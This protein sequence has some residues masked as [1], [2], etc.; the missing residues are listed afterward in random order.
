MPNTTPIVVAAPAQPTVFALPTVP[1]EFGVVLPPSTLRRINFSALDFVTIRRALVE[2][3][4]AYFPDTFND[5]VASNGVIMFSEL[6]AS[7][8]NTLSLREDVLI[9]EAFLPT[10]QTKTAVSEHLALINQAIKR[11]TP[12]T[13]DIEASINI[14]AVTAVNI[15]PGFLFN[16]VGSDGKPLTYEIYRAPGDFTS[17]ISIPPGKAGVVAFGIE[18]KFADTFTVTSAGGPSQ[19]VDILGTDI[20][21]APIIVTVTTGVTV[22]EFTRVADL[23]SFG[24]NDPVYQVRFLDDRARLTFGDD[25][26][27]KAPLAG[28]IISVRYRVGGG[29]RGRIGTNTINETR[30]INP[31]APASAPIEVLFRNIG[32][33]NGGT[34]EESLE[35]AKS[36]APKEA[37]T[38]N[39]ATSGEDYAVLART[40]THPVFGTVLR[41]VAALRTGVEQPMA[42]L[43]QQVRAA[44]TV[45]DAV[46]ILD[47]NFINRNIVEVYVLAEG[48]QS[49]PVTPSAGLK[50]G[51]AQFFADIAVLTDEVRILDGAIKPVS[52]R[53]NVVISRS[54]DAG[55]VKAAVTNTINQFFNISNFDMGTPLYLSNL[56]EAIQSV[57]GVK[58]TT[59]FDPVDDIIPTGQLA[60]PNSAGIGFN[61]IITLGDVKLSFYFER[62]AASPTSPT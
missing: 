33:S 60:V 28:Q 34:D 56:S 18:G 49:I 40:F 58:F 1:Q 42:A 2:Y 29:I 9:A 26:T 53:A 41:A 57:P 45:D 16:L 24:A 15:P 23:A 10:A 25:V 20:L 12:A 61:E 59:I 38:L 13:V 21:D 50:Q 44:V 8:G 3:I 48:P 30:P 31:E 11:A 19:M 39:S 22:Q 47:A 35:S 51:L 6:V 62:G 52:L 46:A 37:A 4:Q 5:F 55:T 17:N 32:P 27:G 43:A 14:A 36:R 7:V 54:A